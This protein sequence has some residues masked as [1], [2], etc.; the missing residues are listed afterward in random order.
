MLLLSALCLHP[1][2]AQVRAPVATTQP[3]GDRSAAAF[4][5]RYPR[6][7][8][9][10][11]TSE[12]QRYAKLLTT[13]KFD[14]MVVPFSVRDYGFSAALMSLMQAQLSHEIARNGKLKVADPWL[15]AR[16][17]GEGR[18]T[19]DIGEALQLADKA[20]ARRVVWGHVGHDRQL[21]MTVVLNVIDRK[22][23]QTLNQSNPSTVL[24]ETRQFT[25]KQSPVEAF[26][27]LI[28]GMLASLGIDHKPATLLTSGAA[29]AS[30]PA[31]PSALYSGAADPLRDA[32]YLQL[33]ALLTPVNAQRT[34]E[35]LVAKSLL[36]LQFV[37]PDVPGYRLGKARGMALLGMRPAALEALGQPATE[38]EKAMQA[39]LNG[40]LPQL[41]AAASRVKSPVTRLMAERE[42]NLV[43]WKYG[44]I[45][46]AFADRQVA[47]LRLGSPWRDLAIRAFRD[48]DDWNQF[49]NVE[50]KGLLDSAFPLQGFTAK[51]LIDGARVLGDPA[52]AQASIEF[53]VRD[54]IMRMQERAPEKW[55]CNADFA[56]VA[57]QDYLDFLEAIA[58]DNIERRVNM[59]NYLQG[60]PEAALQ[61]L[62]ILDPVFKDHP[63]FT[64]LRAQ[65]EANLARSK[66]GSVKEGLLRSSYA[67]AMH[68]LYWESGQTYIA[69]EAFDFLSNLGRSDFGWPGNP[70][71]GDFPMRPYYSDWDAGGN[72]E[73][74]IGNTQSALENSMY[75]IRPIHYLDFYWRKIH[76]N[77]ERADAVFQALG[78]RFNGDPNIARMQAETLR[79]KGDISAAIQAYRQ[80]IKAQPQQWLGYK[81]LGEMLYREG[82]IEEAAQVAMSYPG[83]GP[84]ATEN[85]VAV[86]NYAYEAGSWFYWSGHFEQAIPLYE[87]AAN[88]ETGSAASITGKLRLK[89]LEGDYLGAIE[90]TYARANRY[91]TSYAWRDYIG[92]LYAMGYSKEAWDSFNVLVNQ[93]SAP[94]IWE[95]ALVGHRMAD[96]SE[97]DLVKWASQDMYRH[98]GAL[99]NEAAKYLLRA[100]VVDRT[101]GPTISGAIQSLD[102]P[103]WRVYHALTSMTVKVARDNSAQF[104]VGPK[105][106]EGSTLPIGVFDSVNKNP[107]R[108]E[109][110]RFAEYRRAIHSKD[111]ALANG[112]M[113]TVAND[114]DPNQ[115]SYGY[116]L[117]YYAFAASKAGPA[118]VQ[119]FEKTMA[120]QR[121]TTFDFDFQLARA[122]IKGL[123]GATEESISLMKRA[124]VRRPY[125]ENRP[126]YTE[127]QYAEIAEWLLEATGK[128]GYRTLLLD[129]CRATQKTQPWF[130]WAYAMEA[131]H[132]PNG[133]RRR[134][135]IAMAFYLDPGSE[136]LKTIPRKEIDAAVQEFSARNPFRNLSSAGKRQS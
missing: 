4:P 18:R 135:A 113:V 119:V 64:F 2:A 36:A 41:Q 86:S 44:A 1:A 103:T 108:S 23:G 116:F 27:S 88:L 71:V 17:L 22:D 105:A 87:V 10:W 91:G 101:P 121:P 80:T 89:L 102:P 65:S 48:N 132:A 122:V 16:A 115:P 78:R 73:A 130:A 82:R 34:H 54:H 76:D 26:S 53:S 85:R 93:Q 62:N 120:K 81:E 25:I 33:L 66:E 74:I 51:S 24:S 79:R 123:A 30:F 55:C 47:A 96:T 52:K 124:A 49:S 110:A 58:N 99:G 129:W 92:M 118:A 38:E 37:S 67:N 128:P 57:A 107:V 42:A 3:V 111:Y 43:G 84:G 35:R 45:D 8:S 14:V 59:Q 50:P 109:L 31:D 21:N 6:P 40:D 32:Y 56:R 28:P 15:V 20:G 12:K 117:P 77:G 60:R 72:P 19:I 100:A 133:P 94:H 134:Q 5:P 127:Y 104:V 9:Q 75:D 7:V 70:Y 112:L 98:A 13:G 95:T 63:R 131:K 69:A 106:D 90:G 114:F 39:F 125:T 68:A 46:T 29:P 11:Q 61:Q 126:I 97:P 83:F 136:R